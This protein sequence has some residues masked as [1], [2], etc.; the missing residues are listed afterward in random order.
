[1]VNIK[2]TGPRNFNF[3][4]VGGISEF[5][6][7]VPGPGAL[8]EVAGRGEPG[9]LEADVRWFLAIGGGGHYEVVEAAEEAEPEPEPAEDEAA[10]G[11]PEAEP[12]AE[13]MAGAE[14]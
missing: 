9:V 13:A 14:E 6:Y 1:M 11:E 4:I 7:Y 12:E 5:L 2:Y 3:R 10:G 8:V